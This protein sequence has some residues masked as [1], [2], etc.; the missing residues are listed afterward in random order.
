MSD[1]HSVDRSTPHV[2]ADGWLQSLFPFPGNTRVLDRF[3]GLWRA[4]GCPAEMALFGRTTAGYR[5]QVY[6]LTP[7]AALFAAALPGCWTSAVDPTSVGWSLQVGRCDAR[8]LF[9]LGHELLKG[10]VC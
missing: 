9:G 8:P 2:A 3:S 10:R 4:Q 5:Q 1:G 7:A 6:L